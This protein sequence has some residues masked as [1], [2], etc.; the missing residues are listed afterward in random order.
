MRVRLVLAFAS[1]TAFNLACVAA[2]ATAG[3]RAQTDRIELAQNALQPIPKAS[4][5][6]RGEL[7]GWDDA[8]PAAKPASKPAAKAAPARKTATAAK[9]KA[10]PAEKAARDRD[11]GGLPL[12]SSREDS[13]GSPVSFDKN[14]NIGTGFKF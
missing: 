5:R 12:P 8:K 9:A 14:G 1:A 2:P 11:D 4:D 3:G 7:E 6:R 13:T 10:K